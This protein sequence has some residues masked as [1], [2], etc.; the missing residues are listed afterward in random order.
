MQETSQ[1][2]AVLQAKLLATK[3]SSFQEMI[4]MAMLYL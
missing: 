2:K 1:A 4:K 3:I